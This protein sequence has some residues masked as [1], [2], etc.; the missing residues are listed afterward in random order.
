MGNPAKK[1][2]ENASQNNLKI[3]QEREKWQQEFVS[4]QD[5]MTQQVKQRRE[6][7]KVPKAA[8]AFMAIWAGVFGFSILL[9]L[10]SFNPATK[11][12]V[13]SIIG[14]FKVF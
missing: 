3:M 8:W 5:Y 14:A 2:N 11:G 10:M 1:N 13:K 7:R 9:F 12:I 6:L 4:R